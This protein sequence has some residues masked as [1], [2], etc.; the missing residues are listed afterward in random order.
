MTKNSLYGIF[1]TAVAVGMLWSIAA[2]AQVLDVPMDDLA[3]WTALSY[4]NIPA[5][6]VSIV[7]GA[8]HVAVNGSAGP[9]VHR[10][11]APTMVKRVTLK[12]RYNGLLA[13]PDTAVQ[14]D[15][16]AD[17]F[18]LRLGLVEAGEQ[19]LNW[20]QRKIAADWIVKLYELAPRGSG[21]RRINFLT[22]T[23]QANLVGATRIHPL[24]DLMHETRVV[25]LEGPGEFE[26]TH[27]FAEPVETLGLWLSIDGDDT[28]SMFEVDI[29]S[30]TLTA[31]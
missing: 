19:T 20:F 26:L 28:G 30:V 25:Y 11:P 9:L 7:D 16:S 8:L 23:Q 17:D 29:R 14:G 13:L 10:L 22:T 12:A 1:Q 2:Q 21:V 15:K 31:P 5:N 18:V 4:R 24:S 6:R 27:T 3:A